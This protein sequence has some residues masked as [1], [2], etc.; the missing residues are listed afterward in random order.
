MVTCLQRRP[1]ADLTGAVSLEE[2][3]LGSL[4]QFVKSDGDCEER[5]SSVFAVKEVCVSGHVRYIK[6]VHSLKEKREQPKMLEFSCPVIAC[7]FLLI[8]KWHT[9]KA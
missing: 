4:Q 1:S 7:N 5:G 8:S 2:A 3:K 6:I 9:W